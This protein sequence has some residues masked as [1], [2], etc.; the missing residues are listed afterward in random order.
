M[1]FSEFRPRSATYKARRICPPLL[2]TVEWGDKIVLIIEY[3]R[4]LKKDFIV[5][6]KPLYRHSRGETKLRAS[7]D[8]VENRFGIFWI[9]VQSL[10]ATAVCE[11]DEQRMRFLDTAWKCNM[12]EHTLEKDWPRVMLVW[13]VKK[14]REFNIAWR[15][16]TSY[17]LS[18]KIFKLNITYV[19]KLTACNLILKNKRVE[20]NKKSFSLDSLNMNHTY[21][22]WSI[23]SIRLY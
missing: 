13:P 11:V 10:I 4:K 22:S 17:K 23:I 18:K 2:Y 12:L 1:T 14:G 15:L 21:W 16:G 20:K 5:S 6:F 19:M 3:V 7:E 8:P 9:P